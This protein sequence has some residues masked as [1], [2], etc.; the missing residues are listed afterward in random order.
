MVGAKSSKLALFLA[1]LACL[2]AVLANGANLHA[3]LATLIPQ[4][5]AVISQIM[6]NERAYIDPRNNVNYATLSKELRNRGLLNLNITNGANT[7]IIFQSSAQNALLLISVLTKS[8]ESMGYKYFLSSFFE[9][10][11]GL[12]RWGVV[13]NSRTLID[14]G[15]LYVELL[16]KRAYI[17]SIKRQ[18]ETSFIYE[19]DAHNAILDGMDLS[20]SGVRPKDAYFISCAGRASVLIKT[21][22]GDNWTPL[23]YVFDKNLRLLQTLRDQEAKSELDLRLPNGA[24][25]VMIDDALSLENIKQGLNIELR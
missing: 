16:K 15:A 7:N 17:K 1:T 4:N 14:P 6:A 24:F 22:E 8:L 5:E 20:I 3:D 21:N 9:T 25:Y 19:I 2:C 11:E 13:P 10:N 23:I 12:V 18:G